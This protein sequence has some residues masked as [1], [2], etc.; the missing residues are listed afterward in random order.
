MFQEL[1]KKI[2]VDWCGWTINVTEPHPDKY[3][4]AVAPHT[5]NWDFIIGQLFSHSLGI[6][7]NFMMK[8]S[9]FF[10]PMGILMRHLGGIP[11]KRSKHMKSTERII[12]EALD[13]KE[14]RLCI[15]PEGT[16]Q[17]TTKWKTG[18]YYI[19]LGARLPILLYGVDFE[20]KLIECTKTVIPSGDIEKDMAEIKAYFKNYKGKKPEKFAI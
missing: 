3:I 12:R 11:V 20:R 5:S 8:S 14:F 10:W 13:Q 6:R 17:A 19:A 9:W 15:T 18:F 2:L 7:I 16:R 4:I 1:S